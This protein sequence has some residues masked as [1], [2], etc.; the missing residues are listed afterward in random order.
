MK[1]GFVKRILAM[2]GLVTL[3]VTPAQAEQGVSDNEIIIGAH[4]ALSGPAAIWGVDSTRLARMMFEE[5]NAKGGIHGRKIRYIVEDTQYQVPLA[6]KAVNKLLNR[7]K[8]FAMHLALGTGHNNAVFKRQFAK[9]VPNLFPLTGA[10]SMGLPLHKLKFQSLST[11]QQQARSGIRYFNKTKGHDRICTFVQDTDYGQEVI[12][13][14]DKEVKAMG[15]KLVGE[16]KHKPTE[17]EFIGSMTSLKNANCDLIVFGTIIADAIRGYSTA[18]KLGITA[19]MIGNVASSERIVA[20]AKNGATEG[21]YVATSSRAVYR[22]MNPSDQQLDLIERFNKRYGSDPTGAII[23]AHMQTKLLLKGL[24]DAGRDLTVDSFVAAMEN[25]KNFDDG[26][27]TP[28][29]SY[30]STNHV[31]TDGVML[32]VVKSGKFVPV[33]DDIHKM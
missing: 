18:R 29:H 10:V 9:N 22:D 3:L 32:D 24:E 33:A 13:A 5:V 12:D 26:I 14:V 8:I 6:V 1:S 23:Y 27:G 7:D 19:D 31:G 25:I 11:Y 28:L 30:S 2:M 15:L 16:A 4:T 20:A 21:F 17:T